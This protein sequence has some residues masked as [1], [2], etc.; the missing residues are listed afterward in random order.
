MANS[1][2]NIVITPNIGST[3]ADPTIV[4]SGANSSTGPQNIT[5][6]AYP[7]NNGTLSID[8][9]AGQLFSVT[10]SMSG[11][12]FSVNDVSGI[13]SIEVIDTG[14]VRIARYSGN[15]LV[16]GTAPIDNSKLLVTQT[17]D[18]AGIAI[19][20]ASPGGSAHIRNVSTQSNFTAMYMLSS[21]STVA[22]G[23]YCSGSTTNY[24]S[25][26]DYRLK[27]N[28][29]PLQNGLA[30]TLQMKPSEWE[31]KDTGNYGSGFIAHELQEV[32]PHAV[33]GEKDAVDEDG[34]IKPQGV[35]TSFLVGILTA[36]IQEQQALITSLTARVAALESK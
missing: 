24:A 15:L 6:K 13:P 29:R 23:I 34:N 9:S 33:T 11:T 16:G 27:E 30:L 28:I 10:N 35:D 12:I 4:F 26:S 1:D 5:I 32:C 3:T 25:G 18:R 21:T 17:G 19:L 14:D 31:W 20:G 22:G 2:K 36:S 7:T 8:G